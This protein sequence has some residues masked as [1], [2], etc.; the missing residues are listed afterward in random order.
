M[1]HVWFDPGRRDWQSCWIK[2][3]IDASLKGKI[4]LIS[5]WRFD[6]RAQLLIAWGE[7]SV[8]RTDH[9]PGVKHQSVLEF[10]HSRL[11][12]MMMFW[13]DICKGQGSEVKGIYFCIFLYLTCWQTMP[14]FPF[15]KELWFTASR[16]AGTPTVSPHTTHEQFVDWYHR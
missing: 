3:L 14:L 5:Y 6:S 12:E 7:R 10:S 2:R 1:G 16:I 9:T 11:R 13:Q 15:R 4:A 8:F